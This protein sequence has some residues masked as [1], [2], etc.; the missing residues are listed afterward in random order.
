MGSSDA[1]SENKT[2][3]S[4]KK[5]K[6]DFKISNKN[7]NPKRRIEFYEFYESFQIKNSKRRIE[8]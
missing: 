1:Q 5:K 3:E 7:Q 6:T 8:F 4:L 2:S